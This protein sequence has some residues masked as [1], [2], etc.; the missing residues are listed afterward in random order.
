MAHDAQRS[1]PPAWIAPVQTGMPLT[2]LPAAAC[3][4]DSIRAR[5]SKGGGR[6]AKQE[7]ALEQTVQRLQHKEGKLQS[8]AGRQPTA[9]GSPSGRWRWRWRQWLCVWL[10]QHFRDRAPLF[11]QCCALTWALA[12]PLPLRTRFSIPS[13][14]ASHPRPPLY[15]PLCSVHPDLPG[16][17]GPAAPR[18]QHTHLRCAVAQALWWVK[19]GAEGERGPGA[20]APVATCV[21]LGNE[22]HALARDW[23]AGHRGSSSIQRRPGLPSLPPALPLLQPRRRCACRPGRCCLQQ[24]PLAAFLPPA[25]RR[26]WRQR[27]PLH[28]RRRPSRRPPPASAPAPPPP[29]CRQPPHRRFSL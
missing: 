14:I 20:Q 2:S 29:R 21:E 7:A 28:L 8:E 1:L 23:L 9:V 13:S 6:D 26:Q 5:L 12:F 3:R 15:P 25:S 10:A 18:S 17:G 22:S 11:I 16:A 4:V 27:P 24:M 19:E